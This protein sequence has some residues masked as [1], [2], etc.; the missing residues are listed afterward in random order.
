MGRGVERV[1]KVEESCVCCGVW[2]SP[3]VVESERRNSYRAEYETGKFAVED[4][5][6]CE[7]Y[8]PDSQARVACV[9]R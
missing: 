1:H 5:K 6:E 9:P 3:Q 2:Q 4:R 8:L 7:D